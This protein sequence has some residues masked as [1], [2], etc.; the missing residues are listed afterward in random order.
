CEE[1]M[2]VVMWIGPQITIELV[3]QNHFQ[4]GTIDNKAVINNGSNNGRTR[5]W[6][7]SLSTFPHGLIIRIENYYFLERPIKFEKDFVIK[8]LKSLIRTFVEEDSSNCY[9]Q[10]SLSRFL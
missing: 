5:S 2:D 3:F 8:E 7:Y 9:I 1:F 4:V 10:D 6:C